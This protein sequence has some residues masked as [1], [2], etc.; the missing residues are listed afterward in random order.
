VSG[1]PVVVELRD[2]TRADARCGSNR[3]YFAHRRRHEAVCGDCKAAHY[4]YQGV[5]NA[6]RT[7]A[8]A[9]LA[10]E[11]PERFHELYAEEKPA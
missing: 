11:Y 10:R 7:R 3:G 9:R 8:L 5:L 4:A 1:K 2:G 6:A